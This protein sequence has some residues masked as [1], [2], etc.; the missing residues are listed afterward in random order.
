MKRC[1]HTKTREINNAEVDKKYHTSHFF[2]L[3]LLCGDEIYGKL[4][5]LVK[6][7]SVTSSFQPTKFS[8]FSTRLIFGYVV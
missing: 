3:H 1:R 5:I 8:A 2:I 6:V 7:T 4:V